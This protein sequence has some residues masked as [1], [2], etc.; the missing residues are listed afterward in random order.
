MLALYNYY[1][2]RS[3]FGDL[4]LLEIFRK[5]IEDDFGEQVV[6]PF[7]SKNRIKYFQKF[8]P[9]AISGF[10]DCKSWRA[11]IYAGGGNFGEPNRVSRRKY[12]GE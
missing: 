5:W 4:L 3:N 8:F 2:D 1:A 7:I 12:T 9:A 11:L 10:Q 6:F